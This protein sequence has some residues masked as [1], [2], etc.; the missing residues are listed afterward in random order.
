MSDLRA[1]VSEL[2]ERT[3]ELVRSHAIWYELVNPE[4]RSKYD[5]VI[6]DHEDFFASTAQAHFQAITIIA[7]QLFDKKKGT[8]SFPNVILSLKPDDTAL[9]EKLRK[10]IERDWPVLVR[11]FDVRGNV[12][13]HRNAALRPED[14]FA[15]AR[16]SPGIMTTVL[17]LVEKIVSML[18]EKVGIEAAIDMHMELL[19]RAEY[20]RTDLRTI[21]KLLGDTPSNRRVQG[22]AP[23][24]A[25]S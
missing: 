12:Y 1:P 6:R 25:R 7:Y 5:V 10:M 8:T 20:A 21:L 22:D 13:A 18:S 3:V 2:I 9:A 17:S 15:R 16:I 24:A 19:K 14:V 23:L 4:N 11:L